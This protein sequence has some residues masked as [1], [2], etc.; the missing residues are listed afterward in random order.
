MTREQYTID[1]SGKILGRLASEIAV[2]LM[3]KNK[4]GFLR[5]KDDGG[6]VIISN[7]DNIKVTGKNEDQKKYYKFSGYPGGI[8][9]ESYKKLFEKDSREVLRRAVLGML[10]KNKLSAR[11]IKRLDMHKGA[12]TQ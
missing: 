1:A 6:I 3:G 12:I 8:K 11:M 7:T 4:P 9:E 5:Y 10:P 2:L